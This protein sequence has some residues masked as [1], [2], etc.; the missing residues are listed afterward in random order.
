MTPSFEAFKRPLAAIA[1][2]G[3]V[4]FVTFV[5]IRDYGVRRHQTL[6][7]YDRLPAGAM[8]ECAYAPP[9]PALPP[10]AGKIPL[11]AAFLQQRVAEAA[12]T[13][14]SD[15][16]TRKPLRM[17]RDPYSAY[18]A[19]AV[20]DTH[21]EVVL[22]DEN[23]FKILVYD[24]AAK[25]TPGSLTEPKRIIGGLNTRI[26]FQC[27]LYIDPTNGDIYAV[28]NDTI[29]TLVIFSRHAMGDVPP[30]R[31]LHTPHGTFGIAVDEEAKELFL[32]VQHDSAIVVF[33]KSAQGTDAP[34]RVLQGDH[35]GL[36]DPH[37][38][39][40]DPKDKLLYVTNH[41]SVHQ[42]RPDAAA[43]KKSHRATSI[44]GWPLTRDY[45]VPGTGKMVPPSI[46]VYAK[47]A[48]GDTPPLR[49]IEG[50]KTQMNWPTGITVDP[51]TKE[52]FVANDG[53]SSVL[54]F[55]RSAKGDVAPIR[56][57][58]GPK[59]LVSNP[60]GVYLDKKNNELWVAN[61]GNHTSTVYRPTADGDTPPLRVIRSA[62]PDRGVPGMGNPHPL[63]YDT[64]RE[65]ILVP[66]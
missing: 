49:V 61:F 12:A 58:K 2:I 6:I 5:A 41:G 47:D 21:N 30:D 42:V 9:A 66:N 13:A 52:I 62:P 35:T 53:G 11:R 10:L 16:A 3:S 26:E 7:S 33:N 31:Q 8:E 59:S 36:A 51:D 24:R 54:V 46:T 48:Q 1:V 28:N 57:L 23:L 32:T 25:P 64:K 34:L 37:A 29:D 22:T 15:M 56:V 40:L 50:P 43:E 63:A 39:A 4:C 60:T 19:V 20:D 45:A 38:M 44:P 14:A 18:S 65:E 17:I 27:G 55:D